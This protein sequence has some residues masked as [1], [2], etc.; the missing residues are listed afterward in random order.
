[1]NWAIHEPSFRFD[2]RAER[3]ECE[4]LFTHPARILQDRLVRRSRTD[5]TRLHAPADWE[6]LEQARAKARKLL[7][8][9][10]VL[11]WGEQK[12]DYYAHKLYA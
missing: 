1:M 10:R 7:H 5:R 11:S 2:I 9:A 12:R 6:K 4:R 8:Q 3:E